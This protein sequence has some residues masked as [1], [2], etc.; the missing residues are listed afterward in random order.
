MTIAR[1]ALGGRIVDPV[2]DAAAPQRLVQ[3]AR[4]VRG[5]DD[6]RPLG[7][8]QRAAL[9]DRDLEVGEELEQEGLELVVGAV[10]LVDQQHASV[11]LAQRREHR[12]LDQEGHRRRCRCV[13]SPAWRIASIWRG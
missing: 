12:P 1:L 13:S 2:I 6:D 8:A 3:L 10:D 7:R 4:A 9:G 11:G 5:E